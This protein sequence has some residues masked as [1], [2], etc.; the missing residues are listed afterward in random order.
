MCP[1]PDTIR[2][3][4]LSHMLP[5]ATDVVMLPTGH[6]MKVM[7][8]LFLTVHILI[9]NGKWL[10]NY[11]TLKSNVSFYTPCI[12]QPKMDW[13]FYCTFLDT[14]STHIFSIRHLDIQ[15]DKAKQ[16]ASMQYLLAV[17]Q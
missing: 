9:V 4:N 10:R 16:Q 11:S 5:A 12:I 3:S 14:L 2:Q 13:Q 1:P 7:I 6:H 15:K 8:V 17:M